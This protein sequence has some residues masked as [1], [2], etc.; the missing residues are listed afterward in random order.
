MVIGITGSSGAGKST[1]CEILNEKYD[2]EIIDADKIARKLT[3]TDKDYLNEIVAN[4][5]K[6]IL[7]ENGTL[8]RKKLA[9]II[10]SDRDKRHLLNSCTFKYIRKEVEEKL[11]ENKNFAI[12]AP[13]LMECKL[14]KLCDITIAVIATNRRD[15]LNRIVKRDKISED[16]ANKRLNA[17]K[18]NKFYTS[19]CNYIILNDDHIKQMEKQLEK[20][21]E[22]NNIT[23]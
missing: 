11:K 16:D 2:I 13:L 22:L 12:D 21:P 14:D 17:Q 18:P 6:E 4:F 5:G 7:H 15:Q 10:Y 9:N 8:N 20:I 23:K 19:H 1:A 3:D